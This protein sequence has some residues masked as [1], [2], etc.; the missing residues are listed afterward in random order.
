MPTFEDYS[1]RYWVL[2]PYGLS[3][4]AQLVGMEKSGSSTLRKDR[5]ILSIVARY[6]P[7]TIP[8]VIERLRRWYNVDDPDVREQIDETLHFLVREQFIEP[9][10]ERISLDRAMVE[11]PVAE[12][13]KKGKEYEA[14]SERGKMKARGFESIPAW[15]V[16]KVDYMTVLGPTSMID[17]IREAVGEE[18]LREKWYRDWPEN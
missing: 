1:S 5:R 15:D 13:L 11:K 17:N 12:Y 8:D 18:E 2:D 16:E 10:A 4:L 7:I 3:Y 9:P 14:Y 6:G